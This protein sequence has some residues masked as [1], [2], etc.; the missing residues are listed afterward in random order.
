MTDTERLETIV[1]AYIEMLVLP[2]APEKPLWNKENMIFGRPPR[3]NYIDNCMIKAVT[4][5]HEVSGDDRLLAYAADFLEYYVS[6]DGDILTMNYA[7][8]NLDNFNGA[9]NLI[10]FRSADRRFERAAEI[11]ASHLEKQ[12]RLNCG[13]FRHKEIYPHQIWLDGSYMVFPFMAEYGMISGKDMMS[14][15][16]RQLEN[17]RRLMRDPGTGLYYHGYDE[18]RSMPWADKRTGLS[19]EFW[20][21]SMG[22]LCAAIADILDFTPKGTAREFCCEMLCELLTALTHCMTSDDLLMQLPAKTKLPKNYVETSG[23]LLFAYAA[24]KAYRLG[25]AGADIAASGRSALLTVSEKYVELREKDAPVLGNICLT[26]GLGGSA[27]RDGSAGYYLGEKVVTND[28][29]GI[30]PLIM[31]YTEYIKNGRS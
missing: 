28:G 8:H 12:P 18:S 20:L 31:A 23:T 10:F 29:K 6:P 9:K 21:R 14:D 22:W 17:I 3:W 5:L 13:S 4:M 2:S 25:A 15:V 30:A 26:A 24:M 19:G 7:D 1:K 16:I 11:L 27:Q